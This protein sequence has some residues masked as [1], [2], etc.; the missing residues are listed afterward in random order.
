MNNPGK[1]FEEDFK[2]SV[3][4]EM[5]LL[6]Q[7][8]AG[9]WGKSSSTRF[10]ISN[11]CDFVLFTGHRLFMLELKS[12]KGKSFSIT[13]VR[14][15]Q[16]KGLTHCSGKQGVK[17]GFILNFRDYNRTFFLSIEEFNQF[18]RE[19]TRKSIPLEHCEEFC[20]ELRAK[21]K[22]TRYRYDITEFI[23]SV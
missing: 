10:T 18:I 3:P 23:R 20:I 16:T 2:K 22:V 4:E 11:I 15:N 8:D 12:F 13:N 17:S 5:L 6:R 9:G 14:E 19:N 21:R 7:K 1:I